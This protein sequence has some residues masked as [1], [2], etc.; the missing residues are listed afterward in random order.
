MPCIG[1]DGR[2]VHFFP[3]D[4][5]LPEERLLHGDDQTRTNSV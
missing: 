4:E 2:A 5:H 3:Y 1:S